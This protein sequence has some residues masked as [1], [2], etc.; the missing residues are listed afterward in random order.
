[1]IAF[2]K[3]WANTKS[4]PH[5]AVLIEGRWG[6]G[7]THFIL[8]LL[9][10]EYFTN[11]KS[12]YLSMFGIADIQ[13][14]ETS[15]FYA[16]ASKFTKTFHK[17]AGFAGSIFSG[18]LTLGTG[19]I[20]RG[21]VNLN[22]VVD[23]AISQ[24]DQ[25]ARNMDEALLV[26]D[27]IER[28]KIPMAELLGVV[29]RFV[30]HGDTRVILVANTDDLNDKDFVAFKEKIVGQSFL[31][32]SDPKNALDSFLLEIEKPC[33]QKILQQY[34]FDIIQL[35]DMSQY[36]N[37]RALRQFIW[38]LAN[39]IERMQDQYREND[40]L[41]KNLI[42]QFFIF[43]V[44]F[45]LDLSEPSTLLR[46]SDLLGKGD[47]DKDDVRHVSDYSLFENKEP[48][49]KKLAIGKYEQYI[50]STVITV[51]Q[52]I[53]ILSSGVIDTER[54]NAELALSDEVAGVGSWPSWKKLWYFYKNDFSDGSAETEFWRDVKDLQSNLSDGTYLEV[55]EFLHVV[56]VSLM[57][58]D[59]DLIE[60][61][62]ADTVVD[63]K[64]YI[65]TYIV[66]N[67]TYER[68][69]DV[70]NRYGLLFSSDGLDYIR[71]DEADFKNVKNHLD[72][73]LEQWH[74]EW[75]I[76][77]AGEQLLSYLNDDDMIR[78]LGNL[79]VINHAPEQLYL[80]E[81]ILATIEAR[82][83]VDNWFKLSRHNEMLLVPSLKDRYSHHPKLLDAEGNWWRN[84][85][86]ELNRR[87]ASSKSKPRNVQIKELVTDIDS[88]F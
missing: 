48:S 45:K 52:W 38:Q 36:H 13:S 29:N 66:Q 47:I 83:F 34:R 44:E 10:D 60:K 55:G 53:S 1:M 16:S 42:T 85:Q 27:D 23:A 37:L 6:S 41:V 68:Y 18:A 15:L 4:K 7:K 31:L 69:R 39:V 88:L 49:P 81:S 12:I 57:L 59:Y 61:S 51:Q 82:K 54:L 73:K 64:A 9:E 65:D 25:S 43:F 56:G 17:G 14:L 70:I 71:R 8:S 33:V 11:R 62:V 78:F 28:C 74:Q 63:L 79:T 80:N 35:Y 26:L 24:L 32:K 21:A 46:P 58:A 67:L 84:V 40:S 86:D 87:I 30:E 75:L 19:G 77:K 22:K 72:Q 5:F 50:I 76:G 3:G 2:L 20:M